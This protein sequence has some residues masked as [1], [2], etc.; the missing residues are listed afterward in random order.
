[1]V[2]NGMTIQ[3]GYSQPME[4]IQHGIK[5]EPSKQNLV[6]EREQ[7]MKESK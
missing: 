5:P 6:N 2:T 4:S 3:T 1:M 7:S